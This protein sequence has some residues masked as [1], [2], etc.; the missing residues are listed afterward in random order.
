MVW[1]EPKRYNR[2]VHIS[3][4]N[5]TGKGIYALGKMDL[6]ECVL[7]YNTKTRQTM[8]QIEYII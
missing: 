3:V 2:R 6:R 4:L 1:D 7:L 5:D 8:D